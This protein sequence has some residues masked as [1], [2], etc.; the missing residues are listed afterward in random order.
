MCKLILVTFRLI[1]ATEKITNTLP[2]DTFRPE[3]DDFGEWIVRFE[4]AIFLSTNVTDKA[5]KELLCRN[6]LSL[7]LDDR[8]RIILGNCKE[9][10]WEKLK[11]ELKGLLTDPQEKYNWRAR[12]STI[13][14][15]GIESFHVL[16]SRIMRAI[17]RY[18]PKSNKEQEYFFRF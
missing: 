2:I 8:S 13:I 17:D 4:T 15:D 11:E 14:W 18:D 10:S 3:S 7:K 1:M 6:W 12:R 16:A 9:T 5:K